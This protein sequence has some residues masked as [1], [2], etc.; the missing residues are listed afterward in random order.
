MRCVDEMS[1]S[2][3]H[4]AIC[5]VPGPQFEEETGRLSDLDKTN[6]MLGVSPGRANDVDNGQVEGAGIDWS[7]VLRRDF[8]LFRGEK[9]P[10]E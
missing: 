4:L 1:E 5:S 9:K 2:L 3:A 7:F 6:G 10:E 8:I